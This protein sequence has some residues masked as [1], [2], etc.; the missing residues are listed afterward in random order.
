MK[1]TRKEYEEYLN[2]ISPDY[3]STDWII[4]GKRRNIHAE[5]KQYGTALR[6]LDPIQ[7][8]VML[9]EYNRNR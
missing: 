5:R 4:A 1:K 7:F 9:N 8:S 3:E 6:K 2:E